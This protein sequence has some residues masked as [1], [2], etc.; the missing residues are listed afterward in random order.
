MLIP[1][2]RVKPVSILVAFLLF[3]PVPSGYAQSV[4]P[5]STC[6]EWQACRDLAERARAAGDYESFHDLAW[7]AVQT[8]GRRDPELFFL[9]ARAQSLSGRP[10]DAMVT[11]QR[12][13]QE[14]HVAK[15]VSQDEDFRR[16]RA[17]P[18]W[19]RMQALIAAEASGQEPEARTQGPA[20][21]KSETSA[22]AEPVENPA[23]A[24]DAPPE[25]EPRT[26]GAGGT[27]EEVA[28]F[29]AGSFDAGGLAYD[30]V[31][32]RFVIGNLPARKLTIVEEGT[33]RAAT[34]SGDAAQL[35]NVR[36]L[37]IDRAQ[38]DLWVVSEGSRDASDDP[39]S[40]LH[41]L[42]LVSG[43]V[44]AVYTAEPSSTPNR[45]VDVAVGRS[46]GVLVLDAAGPRLLRPARKRQALV[47]VMT[48]PPGEVTSL[49]PADDGRTV[50][51]AYADHIARIDV[52]TQQIHRVAGKGLD[53]AGFTR[54]RWHKGS[55]IGAQ[56]R[57]GGQRIV[58]LRLAVNGRSVI[59]ARM[60]DAS[61]APATTLA[62][63]DVLDD[64][65]FYLVAGAPQA[66]IRR[67]R[68]K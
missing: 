21:R 40:E 5:Q 20:A 27:S 37:E 46:M 60:L 8:R 1:G 62:A 32:R 47:Q 4:A 39:I 28:R 67:I 53:A 41:K 11:L 44:L 14:M 65:F 31:S 22:T 19:P 51:V 42:Q 2:C 18:G 26:R 61:E 6:A 52:R 68:L 63:L 7:R 33:N 3:S 64:D 35:L 16:V 13:A 29:S 50:Y 59:S 55:L 10:H 23:T 43:R 54:V 25:R 48:L 30:A 66:S 24:G 36:A 15:D 34:L 12:L 56:A 49:A 9:L 17:L 58:Q 57:D 45:F 38:G